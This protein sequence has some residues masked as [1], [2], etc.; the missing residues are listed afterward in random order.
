MPIATCSSPMNSSSCQKM[1]FGW[2]FCG[3][4]FFLDISFLQRA[5]TL[6]APNYKPLV[7]G[8]GRRNDGTCP[9]ISRLLS[10]D[11][12][13]PTLVIRGFSQKSRNRTD[14]KDA[15]LR[16]HLYP[17]E[18][19]SFPCSTL[20]FAGCLRL[21]FGLTLEELVQL[22]QPHL[23]VTTLLLK[24]ALSCPNE[25]VDPVLVSLARSRLQFNPVREH[26]RIKSDN[27]SD[28]DRWHL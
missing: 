24:C 5:F 17:P 28:A 23:K 27:V 25:A 8:R 15:F 6:F 12:F 26:A 1:Y 19:S 16:V 10:E 20:R 21:R 2:Y 22:S 13:R 9:L 4:G 7:K 3:A 11:V 18:G 14:R